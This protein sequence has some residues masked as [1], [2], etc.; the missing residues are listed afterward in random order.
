MLEH[1]LKGILLNKLFRSFRPY[2]TLAALASTYFSSGCGGC[3]ELGGKPYHEGG[4]ASISDVVSGTEDSYSPQIS[5]DASK[6]PNTTLSLC[7]KDK[8]KDTYFDKSGN[9]PPD[10]SGKCPKKY[11]KV[12]Y[13]TGD[14]VPFDCDGWDDDNTV[15]PGAPEVCDGK[16]NDC[17]GKTDEELFLTCYTNCGEVKMPCKPDGNY[18]PCL[19][20]KEIECDGK[21]DDCNG[22]T[23]DKL[24]QK[25]SNDC[26]GGLEY[27]V[28]GKWKNCDAPQPSTEFCDGYDNDCDGKTDEVGEFDCTNECGKGKQQCVNGVLTPCTAPKPALEICDG[29]DNDCDGE[30]D[31][32]IKTTEI[33]D[34]K[35]NDCDG[36]IDEDTCCTNKWYCQD[37]K[38]GIAC[39]KDDGSITNFVQKGITS[40]NWNELCEAEW[41][42]NSPQWGEVGCEYGQNYLKNT[43]NC[44]TYME[45]Q[46]R[47]EVFFSQSE[48]CPAHKFCKDET[49]VNILF[50]NQQLSPVEVWMNWQSYGKN[51]LEKKILQF[52]ESYLANFD[53]SALPS[54]GTEIQL[55]TSYGG[56]SQNISLDCG[57]KKEFYV[58]QTIAGTQGVDESGAPL[59]FTNYPY[60]PCNRETSVLATFSNHKTMDLEVG[61]NWE[62]R[63]F[64]PMEK[65]LLPPG[66]SY[67][68]MVDKSMLPLEGTNI[69]LWTSS[70]GSSNSIHIGCGSELE[71]KVDWIFGKSE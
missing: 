31:D 13:Y 41:C 60:K 57:S 53:A 50:E 40:F 64:P 24:T 20:E 1:K 22:Q 17:D 19:P 5:P 4:S 65:V 36:K 70:Y 3:F 58:V 12:T 16:D 55:C 43:C 52:G 6:L 69:R 47:G 38:I 35:D 11:T 8:D 27:C 28:N 48:Y 23:D 51:L 30:I 15:Y 37:G 66:G 34:G 42:C 33:C 62:G 26:G 71:F 46:E 68:L 59:E 21:D 14:T 54:G 18:P 2:F 9:Q 7:L 61:F 45:G 49:L 44:I 67:T 10:E 25:C 29:Y 63:G 56:C 32:G 39:V